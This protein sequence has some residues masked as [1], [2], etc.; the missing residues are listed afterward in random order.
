MVIQCLEMIF[1]S[2]FA[3]H[4]NVRVPVHREGFGVVIMG[5]GVCVRVRVRVVNHSIHI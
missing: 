3:T 2:P 5:V 4:W 1:C